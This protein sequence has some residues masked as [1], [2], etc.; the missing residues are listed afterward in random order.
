LGMAISSTLSTWSS[1]CIICAFINLA[2]TV[3]P[4]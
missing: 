3:I 4:L 1:H 2:M